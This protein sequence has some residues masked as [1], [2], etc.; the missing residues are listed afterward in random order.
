MELTNRFRVEALSLKV[1]HG[2]V[3]AKAYRFQ[4]VTMKLRL[5]AQ[6]FGL[7]MSAWTFQHSPGVWPFSQALRQFE[8]K[9][10]RGSKPSSG[11]GRAALSCWSHARI[12]S[13]NEPEVCMLLVMAEVGEEF[14]LP[15]GHHQ[16][17][18]GG[19]PWSYK[20]IY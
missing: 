7:I 4:Q 10:R 3:C 16:I 11:N 13:K 15:L 6:A 18:L 8:Q 9:L 17:R 12:N 14:D 5:Q 1:G 20:L 2:I 19:P